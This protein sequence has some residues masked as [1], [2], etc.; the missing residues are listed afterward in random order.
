MKRV[1]F[2]RWALLFL[3]AAS[4][5]QEQKSTQK[6]FDFDDLIDDQISQLSLR[7]GVLDKEVDMGGE[8]SDS[9]FL[10]SAKGWESELEIF[11][12]LEMI[13]KPMYRDAYKIED[14]VEDTKSNLKIRQ[15]T[16][17]SSPVPLVKFFYQNELSQLKKIEAS[18]TKS[19]L[20]YSTGRVLLMEFEDEE[21]KPLLFRYS[22]IGFQKMI[23]SDTV[24]FSVSG[25]IDW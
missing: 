21:G 23:L 19:N 7:I 18:V 6:F 10:P 4:C 2:G 15:Y 12:Q 11:R 24:R 3:M 9:T 25:Q 5:S 8:K 16:A 14:P 20:L 13:N 22:V 17:V 1:T